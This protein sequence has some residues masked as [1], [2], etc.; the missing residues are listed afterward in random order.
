MKIIE[1]SNAQI[2]TIIVALLGGELDH[3]DREDIAIKADE[4]AHGKFNW[5]KYPNKI[6][7]NT[8]TV[9][10]NDAKK[11]RNGNLIVGNNQ[12]GWMLSDNGLKWLL[13]LS[14]LNNLEDLHVDSLVKKILDSLQIEIERLLATQAHIKQISGEADSITERDFFEFT[15]T[16]EYFKIKAKERR[17]TIIQNAVS[18]YPALKI[19]WNTLKQKF[20]KENKK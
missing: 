1:F 4:L 2:V 17:Y 10:L 13:S 7:L 3:I 18:N 11:A 5:R 12:R 19:T 15:R 6:D 16:N 20:L 14:Q 9:A 8:V